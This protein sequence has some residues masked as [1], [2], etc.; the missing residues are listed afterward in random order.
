MSMVKVVFLNN[1]VVK[2]GKTAFIFKKK[3]RNC[4]LIDYLKKTTPELWS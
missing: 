2:T 1:Y 3:R 4:Y